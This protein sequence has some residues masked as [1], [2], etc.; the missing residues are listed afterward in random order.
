M[1]GLYEGDVT[2][3]DMALSGNAGCVCVCILALTVPQPPLTSLEF[4]FGVN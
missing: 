2:L 1:K 4:I 3:S